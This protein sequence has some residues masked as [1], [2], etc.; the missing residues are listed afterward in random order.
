MTNKSTFGGDEIENRFNYHPPS[1]GGV[2]RH[3]E[4][5][6]VYENLAHVIDRIC[7]GGREKSLAMTK[8]EESKFWASA[9][10]ARNPETR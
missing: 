6:A 4:L 1:P 2:E 9:S 5:S 7:P 8:L 3:G 10:V